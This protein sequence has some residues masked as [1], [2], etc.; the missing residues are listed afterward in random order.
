[1]FDNERSKS[2]AYRDAAGRFPAWPEV[3]ESPGRAPR[4]M[5][6]KEG[7]YSIL[8]DETRSRISLYA[9]VS[10]DGRRPRTSL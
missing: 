10:T 1:M 6:Q 2:L 8:S 9:R 5:E 4:G 7:G 3:R